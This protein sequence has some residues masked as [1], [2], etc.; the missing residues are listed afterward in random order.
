MTL[1]R[2]QQAHLNSAQEMAAIAG[3]ELTVKIEESRY[4]TYL[5]ISGETAS[6]LNGGVYVTYSVGK[7]G[8][9]TYAGAV[10]GYRPE[11]KPMAKHLVVNQRWLREEIQKQQ[12]AA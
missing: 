12:R 7:R 6:V 9:I 11:T 4:G 3:V 10:S 8:G 1:S 2:A 5:A